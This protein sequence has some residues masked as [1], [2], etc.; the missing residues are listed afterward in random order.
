MSFAFSD[1]GGAGP[2]K[3]QLMEELARYHGS[4]DCAYLQLYLY[5]FQNVFVPI[6][7]CISPTYET[8][9][10][11]IQIVLPEKVQLMKELARYQEC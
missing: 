6:T 3:V 10:P 8:Y 1:D 5:K 11:Q 9:F 2:E 4:A 7:K